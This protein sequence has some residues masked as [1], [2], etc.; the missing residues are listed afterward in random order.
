MIA[1]MT[2]TLSGRLSVMLIIAM[3]M[4]IMSPA[5]AA[6]KSKLESVTIS[7]VTNL[8][9]DTHISAGKAEGI[10]VGATGS[11]QRDGKEI[12]KYRVIDVNWGISRIEIYDLQQ[13][14]TVKPGDAAPITSNPP[15]AKSKS[16]TW[17]VIGIVAAVGLIAALASGG[18]G[19][20]GGPKADSITLTAQKNS[21][22]DNDGNV[23]VTVNLTAK[24]NKANGDAIED[25]TLAIFNTTAGTLDHTQTR[26]MAGAAK[27]VLTYDSAI[28]TAPEATVTVRCA[29]K[30]R[31]TTVSFTSSVE[32]TAS[33]KTIQIVGS[34]GTVTQTTVEATCFDIMG[35]PAAS[36]SVTFSSTFGD[37]A[38]TASI[39]AGG[40]ATA[41]FTSDRAG[42][43]VVTAK[44][45]NST[46]TTTITVQAGPPT[47]VNLTSNASSLPCDGNSL[48]KITAEVADAGGNPATDGTV[49]TFSVEPDGSGGGNGTIT[50][51]A[52]TKNGVATAS[53]ITKDAGG[54]KSLPGVATVKAKVLTSQPSNIPA[55]ASDLENTIAVTFTPI[56]STEVGSVGLNADRMNIRN[57]VGNETNLTALVMATGGLTVPDGTQVVFSSTH[58]AISNVT[59]TVG[60]Q[61]TAV[62]KADGSAGDGNVVVTATAGGV[63]SPPLTIIFSGPPVEG[64]CE[65]VITPDSL[66]KSGGQATV[67]VTARDAN[68]HPIVDNT[69][70]SAVT[71]K[72]T[73]LSPT[74]QTSDG[75]AMFTLLTSIDSASPTEA[76]EGLVTVTIPSGGAG[77][78]VT[79]KKTF[80]V[81][82]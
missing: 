13:G 51:Q 42:K 6:D 5:F 7:S 82:P 57:A 24:V 68:N 32:L 78:N 10:S 1:G 21:V 34:G 47:I 61:A 63:T 8:A 56:A 44:Y 25:G 58:G 17:K 22:L 14:Y 73:L 15:A 37:I 62:L 55:P 38:D 30:S 27:A 12:A 23:K 31:T 39:G 80:T 81:L 53:L 35:N 69:T 29:G 79:L 49:V 64:N 75:V 54:V 50:A 19:G 26:T 76:G 28:D 48:A 70:V 40:K 20:G 11:I 43:A 59:T 52:T 18:G 60:G 77:S 65:L 66:A 36:G 67:T 74:D 46:A 4:S 71:S 33:P 2:R 3:L 41:V 9:G 16:S 72:G 45:L